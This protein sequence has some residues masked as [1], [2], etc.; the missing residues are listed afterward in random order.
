[1]NFILKILPINFIN[2]FTISWSCK[3]LIFFNINNGQNFDGLF[4]QA[5]FESNEPGIL[6]PSYSY[7]LPDLKS[8]KP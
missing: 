5:K 8:K 1:M 6:D 7:A 3:N 2:I 4:F